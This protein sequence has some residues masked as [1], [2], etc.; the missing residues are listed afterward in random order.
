[1]EKLNRNSAT[2]YRDGRCILCNESR[3]VAGYDVHAEQHLASG[4]ALVVVD[5]IRGERRERV[6]PM[7]DMPREPDVEP[8]FKRQLDAKLKAI[9]NAYRKK[10]R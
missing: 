7:S 2:L 5:R 1:M 6:L 10:P 8:D 4:E 3:T 9:I